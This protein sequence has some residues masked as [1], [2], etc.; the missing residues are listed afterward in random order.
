MWNNNIDAE[1]YTDNVRDIII[2]M[3]IGLDCLKKKCLDCLMDKEMLIFGDKGCSNDRKCCFY[4]K[5]RFNLGI[6]F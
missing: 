2:E 4:Y 6:K 1:F 3:L 5:N